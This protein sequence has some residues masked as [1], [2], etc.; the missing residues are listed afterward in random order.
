[1]KCAGIV[2]EYNP[3]HNGHLYHLQKTVEKT[4]A[5]CIIAVMS[6]NFLQRGEPALVSKFSRTKMALAAGVDLVVELPYAFAT[7][8]AETFATGAVQILADLG[9]QYLCFGSESGK[10]DD[11]YR[12][13]NFIEQNKE[14]FNRSVQTYMK[15]GISY[16]KACSMA[17]RSLNPTGMMVDLSKPNNILGYH[18]MK[19]I[20]KQ[21]RSITPIT[22]KR[23]HSDYHENNLSPKGISSATSIRQALF[24]QTSFPIEA[25]VPKTTWN[26]LIRFKKEYGTFAH[27]ERYWSFLQYRLLHI[28]PKD[29]KNIYEVE[30]GIEH[31]LIGMAKEASHFQAFM[32]KLKTKRYTWTRLQRIITHILTNTTKEEMERRSEK[33]DY[34]RILGLN[35]RGRKYLRKYKDSF[36]TPIISKISSLTEEKIYLDVRAGRTYAFGFDP[37]FRQQMIQLEYARPPIILESDGRPS[38]S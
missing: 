24:S 9:C 16:P 29:L 32:E 2:V 26:E 38:I 10:I 4:G 3:F 12:T 15:T 6:G 37:P 31:R 35:E 30:E 7:Q 27:W 18:Y 5:D 13:M 17:F 36:P 14:L 1:M 23:I 19:A 21:H 8:K 11:F 28:R 34:I 25:H 33:V 22:I 20:K